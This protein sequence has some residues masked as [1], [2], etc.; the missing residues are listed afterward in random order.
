MM[1]LRLLSQPV[2]VS[3]RREE[4]GSRRMSHCMHPWCSRRQCGCRG[5]LEQPPRCGV[6]VPVPP[7]REALGRYA[8]RARLRGAGA[9]LRCHGEVRIPGGRPGWQSGKPG[10]ALSERRVI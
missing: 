4:K 3:L 5:S 8:V 9:Q 10:S 7:G 1:F 6:A 2:F